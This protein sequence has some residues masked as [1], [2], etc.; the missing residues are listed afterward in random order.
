MGI[1]KTELGKCGTWLWA[2]RNPTCLK[3]RFGGGWEDEGEV[4][5]G[6]GVSGAQVQAKEP[7]CALQAG[8]CLCSPRTTCMGNL[9]KCW[10]LGSIPR[11]GTCT[12]SKHP[13]W[14][15]PSS[16]QPDVVKGLWAEG[17]AM[18]SSVP[19]NLVGRVTGRRQRSGGGGK[20]GINQPEAWS[21]GIQSD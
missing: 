17:N 16:R 12:L 8:I 10:F 9:L 13:K 11:P 3:K 15:F 6:G 4:A 2:M 14:I 20:E 18:W 21:E 5:G 1:S 7:G 19:I